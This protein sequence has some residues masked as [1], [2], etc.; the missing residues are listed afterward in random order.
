VLEAELEAEKIGTAPSEFSSATL[1]FYGLAAYH[2]HLPADHELNRPALQWIAVRAKCKPSAVAIVTR[3]RVLE[4]QGVS[5]EAQPPPQ[6]Q[7]QANAKKGRASTT[8]QVRAPSR[9]RE[10]PLRRPT[11]G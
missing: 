2:Q 4:R 9:R 11:V 3:A 7:Q 1:P 8:T 10:V 6:Q 5:I